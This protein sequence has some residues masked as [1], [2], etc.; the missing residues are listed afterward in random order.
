MGFRD[1]FEMFPIDPAPDL[2]LDRRKIVQVRGP[3]VQ[4]EKSRLQTVKI[5]E[6]AQTLC[7][8]MFR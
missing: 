4:I 1:G 8:V 7:L 3:I 6:V 5:A 2:V